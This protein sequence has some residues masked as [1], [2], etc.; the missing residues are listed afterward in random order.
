MGVCRAI[1]GI[2]IGLMAWCSLAPAQQPT[3]ADTTAMI[4]RARQKARQY[5]QS[6]PDFECTETVHRSTSE[7]SGASLSDTLTIK[8][9]YSQRAEVHKLVL[10]NGK[11]TELKFEGLHG[12][13]SVG[14]FGGILHMVFDPASQTAFAW[15]SW[16]NVRQRRSAAYEYA[17]SAATSPYFLRYAGHESMVS[18][19]G[20]VEV[21]ATS[22][23]VLRLTYIC[24][25]IPKE[26]NLTSAS[27]SVD[28]EL[29]GVG[30]Q[31]YLLPARSESQM[32]G[33]AV[34]VRNKMEFTAYH[35]FT[36]DSVID[37]GP[38]K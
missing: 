9:S 15:E 5:T 23:E 10:V 21:D 12:A 14:E 13:T 20:V 24:Y 30:G 19:H 34:V 1:R 2:C 26:L 3:A 38:G 36:T 16:K 35:K 7:G 31:N 37:F 8:L 18:I 22:G 32:R 29:A 17:V 33:P 25:D 11:P 27:G 4:E 28:Y 6:L